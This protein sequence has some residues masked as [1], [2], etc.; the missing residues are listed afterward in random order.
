MVVV[1]VVKHS[2]AL[3]TIL[4]RYAVA[5]IKSAPKVKLMKVIDSMLAMSF[6]PAN[7]PNNLEDADKSVY[8]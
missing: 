4:C 8:F 5:Q 1:Y 7:P 3:L 6:K 2:T